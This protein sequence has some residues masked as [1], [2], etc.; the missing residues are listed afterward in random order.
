MSDIHLEFGVDSPNITPQSDVL[1]LAGDIGGCARNYDWNVTS[2]FLLDMASKFPQVYYVAGNHEFYE[3]EY[4]TVKKQIEQLCP[5][6]PN[7]HF[8]DRDSVL[9]TGDDSNERVRIIGCT[10]WSH[11]PP[12]EEIV[13]SQQL[14]DYHFI[15]YSAHECGQ[16]QSK[17]REL[18]VHDT[19][20]MHQADVQFIEQELIKSRNTGEP[21]AIVVTHDH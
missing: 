5:N 4:W 3:D 15:A 11:V 7:L 14:N 16:S 1:F 19:N 21:K 10:L 8:L 6:I 2:S 17:P 9:W 12:T 18:T 13:V 20:A